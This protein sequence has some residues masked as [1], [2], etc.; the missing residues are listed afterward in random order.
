[1]FVYFDSDG[2][3]SYFL[4]LFDDL[5]YGSLMLLLYL[6]VV[7]DEVSCFDLCFV[8]LEDLCMQFEVGFV[9]FVDGCFECNVW[10]LC[11]D[12][13]LCKFVVIE[14]LLCYG[15]VQGCMLGL[16]EIVLNQWLML[17]VIDYYVILMCVKDIL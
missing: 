13:D 3:V 6:F 17:V 16:I 2:L 4:L 10:V 1:M 14:V 12:C 5:Y 9:C 11:Q 7:F 15:V 8:L